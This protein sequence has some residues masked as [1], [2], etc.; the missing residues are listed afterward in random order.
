MRPLAVIQGRQFVCNF[1]NDHG[2]AQFGYI[3]DAPEIRELIEETKSRMGEIASDS[4]RVE[5]L[6]PA[7]AKLL[8]ADGWLRWCPADS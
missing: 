3:V 8:A 7:F 5:S 1:S 4:T 6:R 2:E